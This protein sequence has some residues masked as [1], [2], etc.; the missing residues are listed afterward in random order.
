VNIHDKNTLWDND[1]HAIIGIDH[2]WCF[3]AD[4]GGSNAYSRTG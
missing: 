2:F 1:R 4:G 3:G